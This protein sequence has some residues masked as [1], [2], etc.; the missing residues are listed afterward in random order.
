MGWLGL[1]G[2]AGWEETR[3]RECPEARHPEVWPQRTH[4]NPPILESQLASSVKDPCPP[5]AT[6]LPHGQDGSLFLGS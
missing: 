5:L 6:I 2:W 3:G 1:E 4:P